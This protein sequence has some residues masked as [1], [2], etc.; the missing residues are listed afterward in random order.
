MLVAIV[1][2]A[3]VVFC[4]WD[5]RILLGK[6]NHTR[7]E[8]PRQEPQL[9]VPVAKPKPDSAGLDSM[10]LSTQYNKQHYE[11]VND[12]IRVMRHQAVF[13]EQAITLDTM[14][15]TTCYNDDDPD[16]SKLAGM[17]LARRDKLIAM[18]TNH[19]WL[20]QQYEELTEIQ[21]K[22]AQLKGFPE[23]NHTLKTLLH[24]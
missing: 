23:A 1:L 8:L 6:R 12:I 15:K 17:I 18:Q 4:I 5:N 16:Y 7:Q 13:T 21:V 2:I 19:I 24:N 9:S 10:P 3:V 14:I 11:L 20:E 22:L